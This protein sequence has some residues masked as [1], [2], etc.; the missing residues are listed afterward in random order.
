MGA[1]LRRLAYL[2][3]RGRE[4]RD[5]AEEMQFHHA[6][7]RRD[8]DAQDSRA[9]SRVMGNTL[10]AREDAR[11]VWIAPRLESLWQDIRIGF[12]SLRRSP[13]LVAVS[14]LS[15]G[16]GIG[17]NSAIYM[18]AITIF[19]HQPTMTEPE[20]VVAVEPG[21][22]N[23]F[24]YPDFQDL[25]AS[26]I[27]ADV[28]GFRTA[29]ANLRLDDVV[30]PMMTLAVSGNF[31]DVLGIDAQLG[32]TFDA[33]EA[34]AR[35]DPRLVVV[36]NAFWR[37]WLGGKADVIG[38]EI[39]LNGQPYTLVGVLPEKYLPVTG[40]VGPELYV[41]ISPLILPTLY[42]RGAPALN[43]M[44]R[45]KPGQSIDQ[46]QPAVTAFGAS[47][48]RTYPERDAGMSKPA[49]VYPATG[50]QFR[51]MP[52]ALIL[53]TGLLWTSVAMVL[54]IGCVNV[55]G[56]LMARAA[57]RRRE[58]AIRVA[59]GAGRGRVIQSMLVESLLLVLCGLVV[60]VP[61]AYV[62]TQS[63]LGQFG[64]F[65]DMMTPDPRLT[66]FAI[67][68]VIVST[69]ICGLV[70][71]LR[72]T[73]AN[74]I[75]EIKQGGDG[76]SPRLWFRHALIVGQVAMSLTLIVLAL[77][78]VRSQIY[79]SAA[80]IGFDIDH[81]VV[82]RFSFDPGQYEGAQRLRF[83]ERVTEEIKTHPAVSVVSVANLVP[84]YGEALAR[85]F[86]PAGLT[87]I[88][89]SRPDTY[90]VGP[91]Y[92]KTLAIPLLGGRDFDDTDT[93]GKPVVAIV[94]ET[95]AKTQFPGENVIGR[96]VQ[97]GTEPSAEIVGLVRDS[98]IDTLGEDPHPVVYFAFAQRPR[99]LFVHV[100]TTADPGVMV[101][102]VAKAIERV[103]TVVPVNV[104]TL[105]RAA[106]SEIT[107]R[108]IATYLAGSIGGAAL[109]LAMIGLYGVMAYVVAS[110]TAEVGIRMTLGASATRI[111]WEVLSSALALV[112]AGV[113][114][115]AATSSALT[116]ALQTFLVGISPY[117]LVAFAVAVALLAASGIVA[118]LVPALRAARVDPMTALRQQ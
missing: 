36:T 7:V 73:R 2:L 21:N 69:L 37:G 115:G 30:T 65:F 43:A 46:A 28:T 31:F 48:E 57:N 102:E 82:A 13:G 101:R 62:V 60:G 90:S 103:D 29:S 74:V 59:V 38:A 12:R 111:G 105:R 112:A 89:G 22:A 88:P 93:A 19:R 72:S 33:S 107:M 26:G 16:L 61:V 45:L 99:Q 106:S 81:G 32:R 40:W 9:A 79:V 85:T 108:R 77:L 42:T 44:A 95:F 104:N 10:L 91:G 18:A 87:D 98:K 25:A 49:V 53:V 96:R 64:Q 84:L 110:R 39:N 83:A 27:F 15:L 23:Q 52:G 100:R 80:D 78:C 55:M 35:R 116:P 34:D 51:G 41:P 109:L 6:M 97:T 17:L 8:G 66:P 92:F 50:M 4:D 11:A 71:A 86:H 67:A 14:A 3:G 47:L 54:L 1:L 118:C 63:T 24:S 68:L 70:P 117:D 58:I 75:T 56:L 94:N 5:L 20:R 113:V 76:G 114:I